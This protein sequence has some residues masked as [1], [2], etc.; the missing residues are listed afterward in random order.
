MRTVLIALLAFS[1]GFLGVGLGVGQ[2]R[3]LYNAYLHAGF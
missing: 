3:F 1:L 2:T